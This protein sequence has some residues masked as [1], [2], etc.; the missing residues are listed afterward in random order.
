[1]LFTKTLKVA[2]IS[3]QLCSQPAS[4]RQSVGEA[5]GGPVWQACLWWYA[6]ARLGQ[7]LQS[8]WGVGDTPVPS[9]SIHFGTIMLPKQSYIQGLTLLQ[10]KTKGHLQDLFVAST[11]ELNSHPRKPE[12]HSSSLIHCKV[13]V[14]SPRHSCFLLP[15]AK[16]QA[17]QPRP[18]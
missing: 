3:T 10:L 18:D 9:L 2:F 6:P 17:Y 11:L 14:P 5:P 12:P 15:M 7:L 13:L 8:P 4:V 16:T 1:M